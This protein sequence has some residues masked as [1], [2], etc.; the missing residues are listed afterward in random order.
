[1][2]A[3]ARRV[4]DASVTMDTT[5]AAMGEYGRRILPL[6]LPADNGGE[7]GPGASGGLPHI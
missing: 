6:E 2:A 7:A 1:M 3:T 5:A 4:S